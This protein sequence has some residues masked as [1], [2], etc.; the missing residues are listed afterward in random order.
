[1]SSY[2]FVN[3]DFLNAGEICVSCNFQGKNYLIVCR[4]Y[5]DITLNVHIQKKK[6]IADLF[7][8]I[9]NVN[10]VAGTYNAHINACR[11]LITFVLSWQFI[12]LLC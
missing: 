8:S 12:T 6:K 1:M 3:F 7:V 11:Y 5:H 10:R 9:N 4:M 2:L